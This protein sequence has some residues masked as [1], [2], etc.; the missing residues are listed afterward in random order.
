MFF[1]SIRMVELVGATVSRRQSSSVVRGSRRNWCSLP[2]WNHALVE[3]RKEPNF[4]YRFLRAIYP[5]SR[6]LFPN[7]V[8]RADDLAR[9]M[10]DVVANRAG[11]RIL[12]APR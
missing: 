5:A 11:M 8:I 3:P 12:F 10:V 9:V 2:L 1:Q 4:G 7:Q 6:V